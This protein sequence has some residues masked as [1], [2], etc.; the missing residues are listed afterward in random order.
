MNA[1][2]KKYYLECQCSTKCHLVV[3]E[4]DEELGLMISVQLVSW[5]GFFKRL[6]SAILYLF[7]KHGPLGDPSWDTCMVKPDDI[8]TIKEWLRNVDD[9]GPGTDYGPSGI[10]T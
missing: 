8:K 2:V 4:Y 6:K 7:K 10:Y 3:L 5:Q 9:H 1:I